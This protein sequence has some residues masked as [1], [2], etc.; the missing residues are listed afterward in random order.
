[1]IALVATLGLTLLVLALLGG[2]AFV[3][4]GSAA[5]RRPNTLPDRPFVPGE[6]LHYAEGAAT[7]DL[8]GEPVRRR[9]K[10]GKRMKR[11]KRGRAAALVVLLVCAAFAPFSTNAQH[12]PA[13]QPASH[14]AFRHGA[15]ADLWN[16]RAAVGELGWQAPD[17]AYVAIVEVH[18]RRARLTGTT[19]AHM[20][21]RYSAA[22]RVPPWHRA[23][24]RELRATSD[25]P[26]AW[27]PNLRRAWPRYAG[28]F[29]EVRA[30]VG[31]VLRGERDEVC[32][33]AEHYGSESDGVPGGQVGRWESACSFEGTS[34]RWWKRTGLEGG[35]QG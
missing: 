29:A 15:D 35:G 24:V 28:R 14:P 23:W 1:M 3:V 19:T 25:V 16:A 33:D 17:E 30:L 5:V 32:P 22:V 21:Q 10:R 26:A 2:I 9:A 11:V 20:A 4:R 27:P 6:V 8:D 13:S 7:L 34:Q 31:E 18:I 12:D